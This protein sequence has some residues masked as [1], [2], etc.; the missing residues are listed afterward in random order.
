MKRISAVLMTML[1]L[2]LLAGSIAVLA[3]CSSGKPEVVVFLGKSSR[4]YADV[5]A[6]IDEAQKKFGN[7]VTFVTY[8]YDSPTSASAKK[9]YFVSMDPTVIIKNA[10]GQTKQ[11]YMGKPMKDELLSTI[12]SFIPGAAGKTSTPGSTP[13]STTIPGTPSPQG[14]TPGGATPVPTPTTTP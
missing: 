4:S 7:K 6:M 2:A 13:N 14:S 9:Q 8:D 12:E 5:K 11:T 10:K 1:C 3:G